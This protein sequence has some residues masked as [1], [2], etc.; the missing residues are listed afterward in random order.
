MSELA[1]ILRKEYKKKE[2]RKP[3]DFS[4]LMEMVEELYDA[5]EPEVVGNN[6]FVIEEQAPKTKQISVSMIPDIEVSELGWSDLRTPAEQGAPTGRTEREVLQAYLDN[7]IGPGGISMLPE[8]IS[9]LSSLADNPA[10][11]V[12]SLQGSDAG[13]GEKIRTVIS[14]LVFYKTLTKI[15]ANF[16]A[17]SAGF[18]FES[19]LATLLGGEQI[20]AAGATTIADFTDADG[21]KISL[22]LYAEKSVEVGGSFDALVGDL[23]RD[24]KMTYLVVTKDLRGSREKLSGELTFYKFDF[25]LDNVMEIL[26]D[27][28]AFSA[29]SIILP[30]EGEETVVGAEAPEKIRANPDEI[31]KAFKQ[32]LVQKLQDQELADQIT[33]NPHFIY[34]TDEMKDLATGEGSLRRYIKGARP[35]ARKRAMEQELRSVPLLADVE[36]L[37]PVMTAIYDSLQTVLQDIEARRTQRKAQVATIVPSFAGY[38]L[39]RKKDKK[40]DREDKADNIKNA[41]VRSAKIYG[42]LDEENKKRALLKTNGYLNDLQFALSKT[43]VIKLAASQAAA[44]KTSPVTGKLAVGMSSLQ[45]MLASC[46]DA[47]NTDIFSIF[48]DLEDLSNSLNSFFAGGL[49]DVGAGGAAATAIDKANSI[50]GKTEEAKAE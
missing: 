33:S 49:V 2:K 43:E 28:K 46:I 29:R 5:I 31:Q 39:P 41:A 38:E 48:S 13:P 44:T 30:L 47:L 19:F 1:K 45:V 26:K 40:E 16:N 35:T 32:N 24:G 12:N 50:E 3:A 22:K 15:V 11:Y 8:K 20:P 37:Q 10:Q 25:T 23:I 17:S 4:M 27:S 6:I 7:I 21:E 36:D 9:Q 14:F 18:S 42:G 34:G